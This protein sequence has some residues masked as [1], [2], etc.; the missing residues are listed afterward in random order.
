M[1]QPGFSGHAADRLVQPGRFAGTII[2]YEAVHSIATWD[3]LRARLLP[4]D[5][6]CYGF[7]HPALGDE[8][9]IFVEVALCDAIPSSIQ[10]LLAQG[11]DELDPA[12][13]KVAVFY[14]ISNCQAG[15]CGH[16]LW[17][18]PDQTSGRGFG[19]G[20]SRP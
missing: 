17:S 16:F 19:R 6:R 15:P 2:R 13:A 14:S 1:V 8:P 9:L 5:R 10:S 4:S 7:F 20:I 12:R 11:R 3:E 18:I